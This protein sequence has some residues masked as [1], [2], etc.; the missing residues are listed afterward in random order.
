MKSVIAVSS[1]HRGEGFA[2][3]QYAIERLKEIVPIW[4]KEFY[5]DG[6]IWVG[7]EADYQRAI[8]RLPAQS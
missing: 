7:S 5:A 8:G 4:K 1:A 2:A 3:C 6:A